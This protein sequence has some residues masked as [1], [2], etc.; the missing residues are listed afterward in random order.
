MPRCCFRPEKC[1]TPRL[2]VRTFA[3]RRFSHEHPSTKSE[4]TTPPKSPLMTPTT[5]HAQ[6]EAS[7][8]PTEE[9]LPLRPKPTYTGTT[10]FQQEG[11]SSKETMRRSTDSPEKTHH[12]RPKSESH[13]ED[14]SKSGGSPVYWERQGPT[15]KCRSTS[16]SP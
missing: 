2:W 16:A 14:C 9:A 4:K 8:Y 15:V 5:H 7:A 10:R 6:R 12:P 3:S 13:R 11:T 1:S